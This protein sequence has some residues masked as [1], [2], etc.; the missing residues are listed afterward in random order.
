M[1]FFSLVV[2]TKGRALELRRLFVSLAAQ[3]ETDFEVVVVDQNVEP[4]LSTILRQAWPFPLRHIPT[5]GATGACRAR[6]VG[7]RLSTGRYVLF[8]DDDCWY[9][10][11]F[12]E[13]LKADVTRLRCD[14]L[15]GRAA[16]ENGRSINGRFESSERQV[17]RSNVWTTSIE[18]VALFDRA[19][20]QRVDGF[21]EGIGIGATTPWQSCESQ[22]IVLRALQA[23]AVCW[24][25]PNIFGHHAEIL[26]DEP[27]DAI[28]K[29]GRSYARGMGFVLRKHRTSWIKRLY[30]VLRPL[31]KSFLS[32]STGR[33][34]AA[35]YYHQVALGR[36]EGSVAR[37]LG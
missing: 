14:I 3:T 15:T 1:A 10:P 7:W 19:V 34:S 17:V 21:D 8:P 25:D 22:D 29:K 12:L 31:A 32:L 5:P 18:W 28:I 6:N 13:S 23:G 2:A 9:P 35:R 30:W 37:L 20:L 36:L 4:L 27:T 16:D 11:R 33:R 24:Y 26:I